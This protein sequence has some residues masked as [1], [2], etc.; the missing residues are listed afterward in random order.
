M[1][2]LSARLKAGNYYYKAPHL[3]KPLTIIAKNSVID[4]T[5]S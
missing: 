2:N 1:E 4:V 5:G 3:I